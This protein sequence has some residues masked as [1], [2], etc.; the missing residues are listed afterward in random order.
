M[1]PNL[2]R[3]F[4]D[5]LVARLLDGLKSLNPT[6]RP[7][8]L[9]MVDDM[10]RRAVEELRRGNSKT[11]L[12]S[13]RS[14]LAL[15]SHNNP[16]RDLAALLNAFIELLPPEMW[17]EPT[18]DVAACSEATPLPEVD[19][20][21][22][23]SHWIT[24]PSVF[25]LPQERRRA[26]LTSIQTRLGEETGVITCPIT[27]ES[28]FEV[29][30]K[31]QPDV[32]VLFE[33]N[34]RGTSQSA[35]ISASQPSLYVHFYSGKALL[36]WFNMS[37]PINPLTRSTIS[38]DDFCRLS[39]P[40]THPSSRPSRSAS[41]RQEE[42]GRREEEATQDQQ[43][44]GSEISW[45]RRGVEGIPIDGGR[46][47]QNDGGRINQR[48]GR[49][50]PVSSNSG[51]VLSS[52]QQSSEDTC[53]Y[54]V[55]STV[56]SSPERSE[57]A[58]GSGVLQTQMY[59]DGDFTVRWRWPPQ[60]GDDGRRHQQQEGI[61]GW[62]RWVIAGLEG[63]LNAVDI[64]QGED[65]RN[66]PEYD[67]NTLTCLPVGS[68][69]IFSERDREDHS[70]FEAQTTSDESRRDEIRVNEEREEGAVSFTGGGSSWLARIF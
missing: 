41:C 36:E 10:V 22:R 53:V 9:E 46:I 11:F 60:E 39:D 44:G 13:L 59:G 21:L 29:D 47:N 1:L 37:L 26:I 19:S 8:Q 16:D 57:V 17:Q 43:F 65:E 15:S 48:E 67:T 66:R 7:H 27:W 61:G 24:K 49:R 51:M 31:V 40:A 55:G 30:Q 58:V 56:N 18:D 25:R 2:R 34:P 38:S 42:G 32:V 68:G 12:S 70:S 54:D 69:P 45:T 4:S 3:T 63:I 33:S 6:L 5:W 20:K 64:I 23:D 62:G 50:G 14:V 52:R 28:L 35:S